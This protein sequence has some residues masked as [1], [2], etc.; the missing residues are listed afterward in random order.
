M[1][2]TF[3][4]VAIPVSVHVVAIVVMNI[5]SAVVALVSV[6]VQVRR[7]SSSEAAEAVGEVAGLVG[8]TIVATLSLT[9]NR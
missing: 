9:S 8:L 1:P 7:I 6:N 5:S 4:K 3:F 2:Q